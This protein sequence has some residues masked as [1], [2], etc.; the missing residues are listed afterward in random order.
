VL[1]FDSRSPRSDYAVAQVRGVAALNDADQVQL[2]GLG[3]VLEPVEEAPSRTQHDG[4]EVDLDLVELAGPDEGLP[5]QT[6]WSG[7]GSSR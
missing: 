6:S 2:D 3:K 7:P 4:D 5:G 1:G